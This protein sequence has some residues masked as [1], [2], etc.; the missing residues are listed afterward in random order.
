MIEPS[1]IPLQTVVACEECLHAIPPG[2]AGWRHRLAK[3]YAVDIKNAC[4]RTIRG[5]VA[6]PRTENL[7]QTAKQ[8]FRAA[9]PLGVWLLI[10]KVLWDVFWAWWQRR[11]A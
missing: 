7:E 1:A 5:L 6:Y 2:I 4:E 9:I 8:K 10:G 11:H 3:A